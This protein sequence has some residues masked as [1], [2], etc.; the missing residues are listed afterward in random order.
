MTKFD[1]VWIETVRQVYAQIAETEIIRITRPDGATIWVTTVILDILMPHN[2]ARSFT[3]WGITEN[4]E[5]VEEKYLE[6][7]DDYPDEVVPLITALIKAS[8][9]QRDPGTAP[10]NEP[11]SRPDELDDTQPAR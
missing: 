1:E 6:G 4:G 2:R 11:A 7:A 3:V 9:D 8:E 10:P 5:R